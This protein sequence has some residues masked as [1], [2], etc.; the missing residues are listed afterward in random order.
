MSLYKVKYTACIYRGGGEVILAFLVV[1]I[2]LLL[3]SCGA[4]FTVVP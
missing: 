2:A 4:F 3:G 1:A